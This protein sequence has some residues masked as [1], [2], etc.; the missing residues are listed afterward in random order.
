MRGVTMSALP[1]VSRCPASAALPQA[2]AE[3]ADAS[4]GTA[5]HRYL[6]RVA[7]VGREE[8]LDEVP[9]DVRPLCEAI[10]LEQLP[11]DPSA[12]AAEV[13]MALDYDTGEAREIGRGRNRNYG[14]LGP[15]EVAGTADVV[16]LLGDDAVYVG[17]YKVG[18]G[19]SR[20]TPPASRNLQL[21]ALALAMAQLHGRG[22]AV[23]E[24]IH[25][26]DD[27]EVWCDRAE[28]DAFDL[29][30][31]GVELQDTADRV[32]Q[33]REQ[34][35][36]GQV[37][38]VSMGPWCRYCPAFASCPGQ[39]ALLRAVAESPS[40]EADELLAL[41]TPQQ[42]AR[43]Y[44]RLQQ[45]KEALKRVEA[46]I[47]AYAREEPI[48]LG[49]GM[50]FGPVEA[51]R[52][53]VDGPVAR[54]VLVRLYGQEVADAAVEYEASKASIDRG[55][56]RLVEHFKQRGERVT[57]KALKEEALKAIRAA[58][59]ITTTTR[60]TVREHRAAPALTEG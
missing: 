8:A 23:V 48:P 29:D 53:A 56:R 54:Q 11:V 49:D 18:W 9:E 27:G 32:D 6:E 40:Q 57:L 33:A 34:V 15:T 16:A 43:A 60:V 13:A 7:Q 17:D 45:V 20:H 26:L 37:P 24:L 1:R 39:T 46:A 55:L 10:D 30:L 28:L 52:D 58:G 22:R 3:S 25:V 47:H 19:H 35:G 51:S 59:G 5:V 2:R 4:R 44:E 12:F 50:V 31:V 42:A 38:E 14:P 41:L 21:R 36:Q